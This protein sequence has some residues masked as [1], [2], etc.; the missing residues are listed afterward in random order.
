MRQEQNFGWQ[1]VNLQWT[2]ATVG[3][4]RDRYARGEGGPMKLGLNDV[5]AFM[6]WFCQIYVLH[7]FAPPGRS[8]PQ[9][10]PP[11]LNRADP[12]CPVMFNLSVI[13]FILTPL[14]YIVIICPLMACAALP[15][16]EAHSVAIAL[17]GWLEMLAAIGM[18]LVNAA[19][20]VYACQCDPGIP[21][22]TGDQTN[23]IILA[24][25]TTGV[26]LASFV[27]TA[28]S[29][30]LLFSQVL[31]VCRNRKPK[32]SLANAAGMFVAKQHGANTL[33]ANSPQV[34]MFKV[35][36][37]ENGVFHFPGLR[38]SPTDVLTAQRARTRDEAIR[39]VADGGHLKTAEGEPSQY[40]VEKDGEI[41]VSTEGDKLQVEFYGIIDYQPPALRPDVVQARTKVDSECYL[42]LA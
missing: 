31:N 39:F 2:R 30:A 34:K 3:L 32:V 23:E 1:G 36:Y 9:A 11:F 38:K 42:P 40:V 25:M 24:K 14:Y 13:A 37:D 22:A 5:V 27:L 15:F 4:V 21:Y 16:K 33:R 12:A 7:C 18:F 6:G 29:A 20:A 26:M 28:C 19:G 8:L 41:M 10:I 35:A 17:A